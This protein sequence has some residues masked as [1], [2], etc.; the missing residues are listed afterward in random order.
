M[1][2][3]ASPLLVDYKYD[4]ELGSALLDK[5]IS[6]AGSYHQEA[7]RCIKQQSRMD[8]LGSI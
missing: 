1:E 8:Y 5:I 2:N 6:K 4:Q 7:A 3:Y